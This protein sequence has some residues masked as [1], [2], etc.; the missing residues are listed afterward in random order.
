MTKNKLK[1][2]TDPKGPKYT[3]ACGFRFLKRCGNHNHFIEEFCAV[4]CFRKK[5]NMLSCRTAGYTTIQSVNE[6]QLFMEPILRT[7]KESAKTTLIGFFRGRTQRSM[8]Q[9][10]ALP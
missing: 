3:E 1:Q 4:F 9:E 10:A 5:E 2:Y 8:E 6:K 7:W